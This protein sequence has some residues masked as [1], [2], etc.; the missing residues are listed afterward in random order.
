[1]SETF[2]DLEQVVQFL[3]ETRKFKSKQDDKIQQLITLLKSKELLGRKVLIFTEFADTARYLKRQLNDAGIKGVAQV[4]SA[5][6]GNAL[7]SFGDLRR[8]TTEVHSTPLLRKVYRR[9][10]S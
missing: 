7:K 5:T 4:D 9:S 8:I 6:K 3:G 1:M 2:Q 10:K